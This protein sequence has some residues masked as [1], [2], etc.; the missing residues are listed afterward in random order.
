MDQ[1]LI[2]FKFINDFIKSSLINLMLSYIM[3]SK[4]SSSLNISALA[5]SKILF[6]VYFKLMSFQA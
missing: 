6:W 5:T 1:N 4:K 2:K 3:S